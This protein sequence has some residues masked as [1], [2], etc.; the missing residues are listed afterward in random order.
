MSPPRAVV[1]LEVHARLRTATKLF[2]RCPNRA[3]APPNT[4]V[5]PVC[6]GHPGTLPTPN[7]QA[8]DLAVL[9]ALA[10]GARVAERSA[11]AR[12]AYFYPDLPK[13]YQV[14]QHDR[15]LASGGR[16]PL[17]GGGGLGIRRLHLEEDA[18]RLLHDETG[19]GVDFNRAGAPLVEVVSEPELGSA[20]AAREAFRELHLLLVTLG[21]CDG[22]LEEGSLRCDAN[23]SLAA[24][25]SGG[26]GGARVEI[27]NLA[28]FR[29]LAR[30]VE[31]EVARQRRLLA[32]GGTVAAETRGFDE[33]TGETFALRGKESAA[34][35]RYQPEPDLPHLS[36]P[37][38][39]LAALAER[40]PE[41]PWERRERLTVELGLPAGDAAR[42]AADP[43]A[44]DYF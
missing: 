5:C 22:R 44:A 8:V 16:L 24:G 31:A 25:G 35:Y 12:K 43:T 40:L 17:P 33:A 39:R 20:D 1:G 7:R 10:L 38:E 3:A 6:L 23:V 15:P 21:V 19:S 34:E 30:A 41:P 29:Q 26:T 42:L 32:A 9:L 36:V 27:K 11:W 2:C 4:L 13:G 18:A 28:S 14:T 37:P